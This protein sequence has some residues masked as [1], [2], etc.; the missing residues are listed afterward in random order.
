MSVETVKKAN[1]VASL[2]HHLKSFGKFTI[3]L[4]CKVDPE[5]VRVRMFE[6]MRNARSF[7][8]VIMGPYGVRVATA[9]WETGGFRVEN[10]IHLAY[11]A[12]SNGARLTRDVLAVLRRAESK[13]V[14]LGLSHNVTGK[15]EREFITPPEREKLK[16]GFNG[17]DAADGRSTLLWQDDFILRFTAERQ[18]TNQLQ[19]ALAG[20]KY[21]LVRMDYMPQVL[22]NVLLG[23]PDLREGSVF[24][25]GVSGRIAMVLDQSGAQVL[26]FAPGSLRWGYYRSMPL[27]SPGG[28]L[29]RDSLIEKM[30]ELL[31]DATKHI[32]AEGTFEIYLLQT[33]SLAHGLVSL[34]KAVELFNE[35][36]RESEIRLT[37]KPVL[38]S[39]DIDFYALLYHP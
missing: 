8:L 10:V 33:D 23:H 27:R 15:H 16:V 32:R 31:E 12:D 5:D 22:L 7:S 35:Q 20:E 18:Y 1:G 26:G 3:G 14:V 25:S 30:M 21:I 9:K 29:T 24:P 38:E 4:G 6:R 2:L 11:A 37:L 34:E 19:D 36:G 28:P 13:Y 17:L 39:T